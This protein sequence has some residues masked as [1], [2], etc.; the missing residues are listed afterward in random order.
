MD[1]MSKDPYPNKA[2]TISSEPNNKAIDAGKDKNKQSSTALFWIKLIFSLFLDC[3]CFYNWGRTTT[4]KAI[5]AI[6][7]LIW[8]ILSA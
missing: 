3:I 5:P 6:A 1:T 4:P 2:E 8:Y 7:K